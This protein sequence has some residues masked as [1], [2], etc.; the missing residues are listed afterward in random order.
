MAGMTKL[1]AGLFTWELGRRAAV[2]C[3]EGKY[4]PIIIS[5]V[6]NV[7]SLG[8]EASCEGEDSGRARARAVM[9]RLGSV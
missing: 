8:C 2:R 7:F 3:L 9:N 1:S 6:M 5:S 4:L